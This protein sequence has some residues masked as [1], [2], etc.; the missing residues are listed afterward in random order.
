LLRVSDAADVG[1]TLASFYDRLS[2]GGV[3]IVEGYERPD[4]RDAVDGFLHAQDAT[5]S[6]DRADSTRACWRKL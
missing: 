6:L 2:T 5:E 1:A 4:R 3:V